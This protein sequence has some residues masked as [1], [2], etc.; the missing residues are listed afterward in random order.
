[1]IPIFVVKIAVVQFT[2]ISSSSLTHWQ[3]PFTKQQ[4][5]LDAEETAR[6]CQLAGVCRSCKKPFEYH[7]F[8][9]VCLS[10]QM[11]CEE[12][13]V[14]HCHIIISED[15]QQQSPMKT[16]KEWQGKPI[17]E[18]CP[19]YAGLYLIPFP[20][21]MC[22][23]KCPLHQNFICPL[24]RKTPCLFSAKHPIMCLLQQNILL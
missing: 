10:M 3:T 24:F 23:L 19:L 16:S 5:Q 11:I 1:M 4:Q 18:H 9:G 8:F 20:N 21:I 6:L 2:Q 22:P 15:Q 13:K 14:S 17:P 7:K 12:G